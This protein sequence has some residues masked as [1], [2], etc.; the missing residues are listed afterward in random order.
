MSVMS[1]ALNG[2]FYEVFSK[3]NQLCSILAAALLALWISIVMKRRPL[4]GIGI[5]VGSSVAY[6]LFG[7]LG[8]LLS[9]S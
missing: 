3:G 1:A 2:N 6:L 7:P 9:S 8:L 4:L 5:L